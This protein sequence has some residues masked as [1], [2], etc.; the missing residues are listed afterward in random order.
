M[1]RRRLS[2][3]SWSLHQTLGAMP[4]TAPSD[5]A[6]GFPDASALPLLDL[7]RQVAK[8][9]IETLELCHFHLPSTQSDYLAQLREQLEAHRVEL[10]SLL[11]DGGDLNGPNRERDFEWICKWIEVAAQLSARNTRVIAGK[12]APTDENLSASIA[13]LGQLSHLAHQRGVRLMTENWFDTL[14]TPTAVHR[15][16]HE[17]EGQLDLCLDF[18]NWHSGSKYSDL[19]S[20]AT[21]ATS[22]H[23][24]A[25]F[26][27]S[28]LLDEAD[29]RRCL[30]LTVAADFHGPFTLI[31]SG[32]IDN[33][34]VAINEAARVA[35]QF[36][37]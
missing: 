7:P 36:C 18:G 9:G 5:K 37:E 2:V 1:N 20:V 13:Q 30:E 32:R 33:E 6:N 25:D 34:W 10:W 23:A 8:H 4:I 27:M 16:F 24:R 11:I 17:L 3:S 21:Y 14:G 15:V 22:C 31:P 29:F 12:G 28:G 35:R 26:G 19:A